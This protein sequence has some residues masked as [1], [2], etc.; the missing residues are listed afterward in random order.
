MGRNTAIPSCSKSLSI[1]DFKVRLASWQLNIAPLG[2]PRPQPW[3]SPVTPSPP[4]FQHD[5]SPFMPFRIQAKYCILSVFAVVTRPLLNISII[6]FFTFTHILPVAV[7]ALLKRAT[8]RKSRYRIIY[9]F[10]LG[11][12]AVH[13]RDAAGP[14]IR[15]FSGQEA[16]RR[17]ELAVHFCL[18]FSLLLEAEWWHCDRYYF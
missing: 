5:L 16:T 1:E 14:L 7:V 9:Y 15:Y 2:S 13:A 8:D 4:P 6:T 10:F 18:A 12:Y 11:L 17:Q 3:S